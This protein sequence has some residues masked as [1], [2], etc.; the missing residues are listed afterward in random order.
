MKAKIQ[1]NLDL[2]V[3]TAMKELVF[4][5]ETNKVTFIDKNLK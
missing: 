2:I 4:K 1:K 3:F 5:K